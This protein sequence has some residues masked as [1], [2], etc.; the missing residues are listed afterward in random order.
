MRLRRRSSTIL[1]ISSGSGGARGG[2]LATFIPLPEVF[3]VTIICRAP[4]VESLAVLLPQVEPQHIKGSLRAPALG[5]ARRAVALRRAE[6]AVALGA[7]LLW[8]RRDTAA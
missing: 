4:G 8:H 1:A 7:L 3:K 2:P 5:S 6:G